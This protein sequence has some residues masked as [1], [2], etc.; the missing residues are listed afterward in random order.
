MCHNAEFL[1][2][3]CVSGAGRKAWTL[4]RRLHFNLA[5]ALCLGAGYD[6]KLDEGGECWSCCWIQKVDI[7]VGNCGLGSHS[8]HCLERC[9]FQYIFIYPFPP[10][11]TMRPWSQDRKQYR[12]EKRS[13]AVEMIIYFYLHISQ[14]HYICRIAQFWLWI[15]VCYTVGKISIIII[16]LLP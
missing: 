13:Y 8:R 10:L 6:C 3:S 2:H 7:A 5:I 4:E 1:M 14:Y 16:F 11:A 9:L 15:N 12:W